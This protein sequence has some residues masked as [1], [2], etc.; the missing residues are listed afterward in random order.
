MCR[1][2]PA[3]VCTLENTVMVGPDKPAI[4]VHVYVYTVH[5]SPLKLPL[6]SPSGEVGVSVRERLTQ[7]HHVCGYT[8]AYH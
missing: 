3:Q 7:L 8:Y 6:P 2:I 1:H 5:N 4:P